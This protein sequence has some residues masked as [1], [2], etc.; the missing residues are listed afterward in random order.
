MWQALSHLNVFFS[1]AATPIFVEDR[2]EPPY[3]TTHF[4]YLCDCGIDAMQCHLAV[5]KMWQGQ[6]CV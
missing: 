3:G 5:C 1:S 2:A 4:S 6:T